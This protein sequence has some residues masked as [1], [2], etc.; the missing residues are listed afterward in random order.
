MKTRNFGDK[1]NNRRLGAMARLQNQLKY[2][3]K[4]PVGTDLTLERVPLTEAD[5]I[6]IKKEIEVLDERTVSKNLAG[7]RRTKKSREGRGLSRR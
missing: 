1:V 4:Q 2:N 5:T 6:R 3:Y 7:L